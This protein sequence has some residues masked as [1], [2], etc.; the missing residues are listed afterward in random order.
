MTYNMN[1]PMVRLCNDLQTSTR[2]FYI[3]NLSLN[4][5]N[6]TSSLCQSGRSFA[7]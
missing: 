3:Q 7:G 4:S 5:L 6:I 1:I 2:V